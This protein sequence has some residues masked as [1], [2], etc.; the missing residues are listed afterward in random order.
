M[1]APRPTTATAALATV[2]WAWAAVLYG[3]ALIADD[4][5]RAPVAVRTVPI[6]AAPYALGAAWLVAG[7]LTV[8]GQ[9]RGH[10]RSRNVGLIAVAVMCLA[11][12]GL[13][14]YAIF[15]DPTAPVGTWVIFAA[16]ALHLLIL[17]YMETRRVRR[18][19]THH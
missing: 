18:D 7:V 8:F 19:A 4:W 6:P 11:Q 5:V 1:T 2:I 17:R 14:V 10:L 13:N 3:V 9:Q 15:T 16:I 12:A